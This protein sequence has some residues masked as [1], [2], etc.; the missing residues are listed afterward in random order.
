MVTALIAKWGVDQLTKNGVSVMLGKDTVQFVKQPNGVFTPPANCTMTLATK[1]FGLQFAT[2]SR[3][4]VQFR[5]ARAAD[6]HR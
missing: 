4:H 2:T 5:F 6:Q 3:Q 1:R